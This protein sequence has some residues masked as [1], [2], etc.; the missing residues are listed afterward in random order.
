MEEKIVD[1]KK[2]T[3]NLSGIYIIVYMV[4]YFI[5]EI[6]ISNKLSELL[7]QNISLVIFGLIIGIVQG[8][9][10]FLV[11]E[12]SMRIAFRKYRI[13]EQDLKKVVKNIYK[14]AIGV[15]A[16]VVISNFVT[17]QSKLQQ[18]IESDY[19]LKAYDSM[20]R[21]IYSEKEY[22]EYLEK[23]EET[24]DELKKDF[25]SAIALKGMWIFIFSGIAGVVQA[26]KVKKYVIN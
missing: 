8:L 1:A 24:I 11:W 21:S 22:Q 13:T 19:S 18:E 20:Y 14:I 16:L 15:C 10:I 2:A 23:K 25:Y 4:V 3:E 5:Y 12:I 17:M 6:L 26:N 9:L 7:G